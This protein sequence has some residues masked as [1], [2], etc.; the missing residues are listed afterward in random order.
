MIRLTLDGSR[1]TTWVRVDQVSTVTGTPRGTS[2]LHLWDGRTVEVVQPPDL[3]AGLVTDP[4]AG[5]VWNARALGAS[6][7]DVK[8][9]EEVW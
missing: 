9:L 3:V 8:R 6:E 4:R 7:E 2:V 5:M 1:A